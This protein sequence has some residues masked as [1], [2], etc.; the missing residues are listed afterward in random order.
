MSELDSLKQYTTVVADTGDIAHRTV[1]ISLFCFISF[2]IAIFKQDLAVGFDELRQR[3]RQ[4]RRGQVGPQLEVAGHRVGDVA[5]AGMAVVTFTVMMAF[6]VM[7]VAFPV[8][9]AV[10][11]ALR[12]RRAR[13]QQGENRQC[14]CR[15]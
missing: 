10:A 8:V 4:D 15:Q 9:T 11:F 13:Q 6:G 14:E 1:G 12:Q 3:R 2:L 7:A 5:F